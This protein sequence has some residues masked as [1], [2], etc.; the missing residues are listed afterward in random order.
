MPAKLA[1]VALEAAA[2]TTA[3]LVVQSDPDYL[4]TIN[5]DSLAAFSIGPYSETRRDP[6]KTPSKGALLLNPWPRLNDALWLL[7]G[8]LPG[9]VNAV[10][11]DK[12]DYWIT[13][14][15]GLQAPAWALEEI[16][17]TGTRGLG[18]WGLPEPIPFVPD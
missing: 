8:L 3:Q 17:W 13:L 4:G 11:S 15:T 2:L 12:Y 9:E 16:D 6:T 10:V 7:L 14:L 18:W 5:D 1:P